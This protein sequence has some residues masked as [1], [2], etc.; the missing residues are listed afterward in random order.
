MNS[1]P[2]VRQYVRQSFTEEQ[3]SDFAGILNELQTDTNKLKDVPGFDDLCVTVDEAIHMMLVE[4]LL[5]EKY[6]VNNI[7]VQC[8]SR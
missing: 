1:I 8:Y 2:E 4:E 3:M 7:I 6:Q 5:P